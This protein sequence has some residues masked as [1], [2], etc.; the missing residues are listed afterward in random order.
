M[1][2]HVP[3]DNLSVRQL[4][5]I[6]DIVRQVLDFI[7]EHDECTPEEL[8]AQ[9]SRVKKTA[10]SVS[11]AADLINRRNELDEIMAYARS[12]I[13]LRPEVMESLGEDNIEGIGFLLEK[14][15]S[16]LEDHPNPTIMTLERFI[17]S[18][19]LSL[20]RYGLCCVVD[21]RSAPTPGKGEAPLAMS[22]ASRSKLL[23]IDIACAIM[24]QLQ[25]LRVA[26]VA[27]GAQA[28]VGRRIAPLQVEVADLL[29]DESTHRDGAADLMRQYKALLKA[30]MPE[31]GIRPPSSCWMQVLQLEEPEAED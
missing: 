26:C 8:F 7:D 5:D 11:A 18:L 16:W 2:R 12:S 20:S 19:R 6:K 10:M 13:S 30:V 15:Q 9:L 3:R 31:V 14:T 21:P 24:E 29:S 27:A 17:E 25:V 23:A 4:R 28:F 22:P 1:L